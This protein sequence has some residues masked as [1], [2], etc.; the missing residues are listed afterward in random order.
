MKN[1]VVNAV[2]FLL[3]VVFGIF[4]KVQIVGSENL[5][6]KGSVILYSNHIGN[7]DMFFIGYRIKRL[8]CWMA[9]EELFKVPIMGSM[10]KFFGAFP[11]KRGTGDI[12]AIKCAIKIIG[13]GNVFG[14]FPEGTRT[15]K[16]KDTSVTIKPG[17]AFITAKTGVPLIPV[18]II[19][20]CKLF[21]K[22]KVIFGKPFNI[23]LEKGKKLSSEELMEI[24]QNIMNKLYL[25]E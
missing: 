14:I 13:E 6:E 25:L 5:P 10:F 19:R 15:L 20:D 7:L 24:S 8:V 12:G 18:K 17:I 21:G 4:Y 22:V 23:E 2:K 3:R 9:K 1:I 16:K 11:I